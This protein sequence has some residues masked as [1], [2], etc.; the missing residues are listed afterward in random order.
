VKHEQLK[1][2][3]RLG[4]TVFTEREIITKDK[5]I[6]IPDRLIFNTVNEVTIID[7]KTGKPDK[8]HQ[9]QIIHYGHALESMNYVVV[10]KILVYI[11]KEITVIE[12]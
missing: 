5:Q 3:F 6:L 11:D 12:V 2:Y 1:T 9:V 10:K 8:K 7:Y 4:K